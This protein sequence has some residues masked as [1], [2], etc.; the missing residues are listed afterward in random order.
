MAHALE[1]LLEAAGQL[2]N[3]GRTDVYLL[4][5]GG[6]AQK[7][8][9]RAQAVDMGLKNVMFIDSVPK[10]EVV[11]YWSLLDVSI[12]HLRDTPLFSTVIPSKLFECM[13][14]GIPVLHG[15][16]GESADI[17]RQ[18]DAGLV[19]EPEDADTLRDL[20]LKMAADRELGSQLGQNGRKASG[21]FDRSVLARNMLDVLE[22][23]ATKSKGRE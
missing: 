1:T 6:G 9:L 2:Q 17:L 8:A 21:R 18:A 19:F 12:I 4:L 11:R 23:V 16:R 3:E 14:M 15:V 13:A 22:D 7:E 5:L 10:E 20:L